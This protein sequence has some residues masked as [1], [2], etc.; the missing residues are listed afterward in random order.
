M[1]V[2]IR[3]FVEIVLVIFLGA[4][5]ATQRLHF[6]GN[7]FRELRLLL[8][9]HLS[10][11]GQLV[12]AGVIDSSAVARALV[13]ALPI[14]TCGLD[15]LEEH[16]EQKL[17]VDHLFVVDHVNRFGM[18]R[19]VGVDFFVARVFGISVCKPHFR[20]RYAFDLF[21]EV[22]SAPEASSCQIDFF[23]CCCFLDLLSLCKN[24][25][26]CCKVT[27]FSRINFDFIGKRII[28]A[29]YLNVNLC[30]DHDFNLY[31]DL[32]PSR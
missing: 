32:A 9:K 12:F 11:D 23:H 14:E 15:G 7:G 30:V 25:F 10:D 13:V 5:E 28:F 16:V 27:L 26:F 17:Q 22:L 8:C 18:A 1:A 2:A 24:A 31:A 3:I 29:K 6:N 20:I 4:I 19:R 21:E